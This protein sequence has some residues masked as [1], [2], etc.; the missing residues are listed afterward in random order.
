MHGRLWVPPKEG[1]LTEVL[2]AGHCSR[3]NIHSGS[4]KMYHNL[5]HDFWRR[6]MKDIA[7]FVAQYLVCQQVKVE[8]GKPTGLM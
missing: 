1:H 4:T 3:Y 8:H 7:E 5:R 6:G 2:E